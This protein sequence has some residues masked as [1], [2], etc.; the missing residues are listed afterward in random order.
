MYPGRGACGVFLNERQFAWM[1]REVRWVTLGKITGKVYIATS[2][3]ERSYGGIFPANI[4]L[5]F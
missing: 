2:M 3:L 4:R 1:L 5:F